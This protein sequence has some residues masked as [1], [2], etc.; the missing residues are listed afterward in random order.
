M[1]T[2]EY[3]KEVSNLNYNSLFTR[4]KRN[5]CFPSTTKT[6]QHLWSD[7]SAFAG[8]ASVTLE[9]GCASRRIKQQVW[10]QGPWLNSMAGDGCGA[11][12]PSWHILGVPA[13]WV[14]LLNWGH[15]G[16]CLCCP[17]SCP[18]KVQGFA[19]CLQ[20][21]KKPFSFMP[22]YEERLFMHA[23]FLILKLPA[24]SLL[25]CLLLFTRFFE[26]ELEG[27]EWILSVIFF[28]HWFSLKSL[29]FLFI[30]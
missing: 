7:T 18:P 13:Q 21:H 17:P 25:A 12:K 26:T 29:Q 14:Q 9:V 19:Y 20:L 8:T 6:T 27:N 2:L 11:S 23:C 24:L 1:L 5:R 15:L 10:V 3:Q 16:S 30:F 28:L 22:N 4:H